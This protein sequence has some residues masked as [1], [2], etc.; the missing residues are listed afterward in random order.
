MAATACPF[1]T[2]STCLCHPPSNHV[3]IRPGLSFSQMDIHAKEAMYRISRL[4]EIHAVYRELAL[5]QWRL[6]Y[7]SPDPHKEVYVVSWDT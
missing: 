1:S 3:Q 2:A 7:D 5:L 6:L 4:L